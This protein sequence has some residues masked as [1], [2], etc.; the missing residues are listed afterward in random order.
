MQTQT[1]RAIASL[2]EA[3][4]HIDQSIRALEELQRSVRAAGR[5]LSIQRTGPPGSVVRDRV[6]AREPS[7]STEK[8]VAGRTQRATVCT[9]LWPVCCMIRVSG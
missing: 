1:D 8:A 2:R 6:K 3:L 4:T 7:H 9:D 5:V